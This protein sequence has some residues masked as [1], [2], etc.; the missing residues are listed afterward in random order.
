MTVSVEC[1]DTESPSVAIESDRTIEIV[2]SH[3]YSPLVFSEQCLKSEVACKQ[4]CVVVIVTISESNIIEIV[5]HST[6]VIKVDIIEIVEKIITQA[7]LVCHTVGQ[8]TGVLTYSVVTHRLGVYCRC[9]Q[10][11]CN[12]C[13][14]GS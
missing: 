9:C 7:Q 3:E 6:D 12:C 4:H 8:E 14:K 1:I 11:N 2:D 5:V 13:E 10:E